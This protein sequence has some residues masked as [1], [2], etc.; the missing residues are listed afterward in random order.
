M[1]GEQRLG[2]IGDYIAQELMKK[3]DVECRVTSLRTCST[4]SSTNSK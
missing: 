1:D 2:G 3:T 4:R